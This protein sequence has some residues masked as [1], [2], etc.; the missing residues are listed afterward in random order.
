VSP[1]TVCS[2]FRC[3]FPGT[4]PLQGRPKPR[5]ILREGWSPLGARPNVA[6]DWNTR[7]PQRNPLPRP[8]TW[9]P[10]CHLLSI[11]SSKG[12]PSRHLC[13]ARLPPPSPRRPPAH[14]RFERVRP[15]VYPPAAQCPPQTAIPPPLPLRDE[16]LPTHLL[17][18][19]RIGLPRECM[20]VCLYLPPVRYVQ[21]WHEALMM[22]IRINTYFYRISEDFRVADPDSGAKH[23]LPGMPILRRFTGNR[24]KTPVPGRRPIPRFPPTQQSA[25]SSQR[26]RA[27]GCLRCRAQ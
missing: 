6:N 13:P 20:Q 3:H 9:L 17:H 10:L 24:R 19:V 18:R 11:R 12:Q 21:V 16:N 4:I 7:P 25:W 2:F 26:P 5:R 8:S 15:G 27:P 14:V 1:S 23:G 22:S